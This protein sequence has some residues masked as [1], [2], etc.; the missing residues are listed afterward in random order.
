MQQHRDVRRP[1]W[2]MLG[3]PIDSEQVCL[4]ASKYLDQA[5]LERVRDSYD[6]IITRFSL[7][8]ATLSVEM[9]RYV[10]IYGPDYATCL[11]SLLQD[12]DPDQPQRSIAQE[13]RELPG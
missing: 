5:Q 13:V 11:Q 10:M 1:D 2:V 8:R 7:P 12:W 3:V 4:F 6:D 9:Q